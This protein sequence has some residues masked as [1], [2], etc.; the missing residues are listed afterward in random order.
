MIK[1][2]QLMAD[3]K[4]YESYARY[5]N[6]QGRYETWDEAVARV[7]SMHRIRYADELEYT[8]EIPKFKKVYGYLDQQLDEFTQKALEVTMPTKIYSLATLMQE[9]QDSYSNKLILGAQRALQFGGEQLLSKNAKMYNCTASYCDRSAFFKEAFWLMLCGCG[10]GFSVQKQ[11]IAKLP[12][13]KARSKQAKAFVVEDSIEGWADAIGALVS[14]F[15]D[16]ESPYAGRKLYFD[17]T[18]IRQKGAEISGGF[19]A[20]GPEPLDKALKLIEKLI[21]D[22]LNKGETKLRSIVAYDVVMH[23]ADAV[24]SGGVRRAATICLFS[25]DDYDMITAKTSDWFVSNPQRGRSNNSAVLLRNSTQFEE[26]QAIME[27][28]QHSGEPGFVW[29]DDLEILFNPCVEVGMYGYTKLGISGWQMCNLT[30]IAGARSTTLETF[31]LQCKTAAIL[32]T[33]QAGYTDFSYLTP[34]TK[35]I[36]DREAL[37]GVGITGW[38]NQPDMLFDPEHQK[39]GAQIVRYWNKV[40][41]ELININ[42][43]A[44]TTVVKPSGN[45]SVLLQCASGIHGEHAPRYIRH[46]QMNKETEV[47][48]LFAET[49]PA[50][51]QESVWTNLDYVIGFPIQPNEGSVYKSDLLGVKQL[52]YVKSAQDNWIEHGTNPECC[53]KPFLKHNV[54]NTIT[55]DDWQEVT[56][57]IYDNRQSLCGISLLSAAG[58]RAYPQA[59]FT[60]VYTEE[61]ILKMYGTEAFLASGLIEAGVNAFNGDLWTAISTCLGEGEVLSDDHKD[62]H[63]R[64]FVRRFENFSKHFMKDISHID[65]ETYER[66]SM[67]LAK[68]ENSLQL[69]ETK[70]KALYRTIDVLEEFSEEF[71]SDSMAESFDKVIEDSEYIKKEL[72]VEITDKKAQLEDTKLY[73]A[74]KEA[75][76]V[77]GNCLKDVYNLHKWWKI[78]HEATNI[79]W[80]TDLGMKEFV[81]VDTLGSQ[82]CAGGACEIEF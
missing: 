43:A 41:S 17:T 30:E 2:A 67:E 35:E 13:I 63:K 49:N 1:P 34:A 37:I 47:A 14:S 51:V 75:K 21:K 68:V 48:K 31:F 15:F 44:R 81:D 23:I 71:Y 26:F 32:G 69:V 61:E 82:G 7:M 55:V 62:L 78:Q 46:V 54:S 70:E 20:P 39:L 64:D 29:T 33:L 27:S 79:N 22:E 60:Q 65:R 38:M 53:V 66:I 73:K 58:D 6:E 45:A 80:A 16:E 42:Q 40:V 4:F 50:M 9:A 24:I 5:N 3:A 18:N 12:G 8:I 74:M 76:H 36:V 57:Y 25:H 11:H 10:I 72:A 52:E 19:K 77:C 59:P 28:V 56:D